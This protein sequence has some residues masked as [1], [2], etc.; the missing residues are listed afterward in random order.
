MDK[1]TYWEPMKLMKRLTLLGIILT[2]AES[3]SNY[4]ISK[5]EIIRGEHTFNKA[6]EGF[7]FSAGKAVDP[8]DSLADVVFSVAE[9]LW[10]FYRT[11]I[12]DLGEIHFDS[13]FVAPDSGYQNGADWGWTHVYVIRTKESHYAKLKACETESGLGFKWAYQTDGSKS[14]NTIT[15]TGIYYF[16]NRGAGN[17]DFSSGTY[18]CPSDSADINYT[19]FD[20]LLIS[21]EMIDIGDILFDSVVQAPTEGYV[22]SEFTMYD[23]VFVIRT[24]EHHY[25]KIDVIWGN[26]N[27]LGAGFL[28]AYQPDGSTNLRTVTITAVENTPDNGDRPKHFLLL[29]NYPNPFN[30]FTTFQVSIPERTHF[31]LQIVNLKSELVKT[32][33]AGYKD[34]GSYQFRWNGCDEG[35]QVVAS[36]VYLC[37]L[38]TKS[39]IEIRKV[40][41]I[42]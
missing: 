23:H 1:R 13:V 32:L 34:E 6:V 10:S 18:N 33:F 12:I 24:K 2:I 36:G 20:T 4:T 21:G 14:L 30:S 31:S 17:F 7:D 27:P 38:R 40:L 11:Q 8:G 16:E 42:K 3:F 41:L 26:E 39:N 9:S 25:A 35:S 19:L 22:D 5:A 15:I 29:Q 37:I 28:W